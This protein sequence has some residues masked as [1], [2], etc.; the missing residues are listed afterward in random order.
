MK[1]L[2]HAALAAL[3]LL[4]LNFKEVEA[5]KI[6]FQNLNYANAIAKAKK[7][8]KLVFLDVY[9]TWCGPCKMLEK[10]VFSQPKV[11]N[12]FN[13]NFICIHID[14]DTDEGQKIAEKLNLEGYPTLYF[15]DG[16]NKVV[17]KTV[18]YLDAEAL[19]AK[20][21]LALHPGNSQSSKL[22]SNV[23]MG[24]PTAGM[25]YQYIAA[26]IEEDQPFQGILTDYLNKNKPEFFLKSDSAFALF[27]ISKQRINQG[28]MPYFVQN[29]KTFRKNY[30]DE[31]IDNF[32]IDV[33]QTELEN[34]QDEK[35]FKAK[36]GDILSF[37]KQTLSLDLYQAIEEK[38]EDI[39]YN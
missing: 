16:N 37:C 14:G 7:E 8:N 38:I 12:Y 31:T 30:G 29:I 21:D 22:K 10:N 33:A 15:I 6:V 20:A 25:M 35:A 13:K 27:R 9:T 1:H 18:G 3:A 32:V 36:K 19:L 24:N 11:G 2:Q 39:S 28:H 23:E 34:C 26:L 4:C 5:Q 17:K